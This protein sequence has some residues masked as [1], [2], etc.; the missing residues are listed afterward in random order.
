MA[1]KLSPV[2]EISVDGELVKVITKTTI[3][4]LPV[5]GK[6]EEEFDTETLGRKEKVRGHV[7]YLGHPLV[8]V[9]FM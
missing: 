6:L 7:T 8:D 1:T 2:L 4:T 5:V 9:C 3:K